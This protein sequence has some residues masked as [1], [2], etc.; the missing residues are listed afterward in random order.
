MKE[1]DVIKKLENVE[2]PVISVQS[3][4]RRLRM[5]LLDTGYLRK[6]RKVAV[7]ELAKNKI[8]GT[9]EI[10]LRGLIS[11]QPVWKMSAIAIFAVALALCL[12]LTLPLDSGSVY[13]QAEEIAQNSSELHSVLGAMN[14]E[15]IEITVIDIGDCEGTVLAQGG[16]G[17]VIA[18]VDLENAEVTEF[19]NFIID[20]EAAIEIAK[21]DPRVQELLDA[22]ATISGVSTMCYCGITGNVQTSEF[23]EFTEARV[24]VEIVDSENIY[25]AHVDMAGG[26]V[27]SI[28][29]TSLEAMSAGL[30]STGFTTVPDLENLDSSGN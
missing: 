24:M 28:T 29:E 15:E 19:F 2:L 5:A 14:G 6:Q 17:S 10:M 12:S 22:G 8:K 18:K 30:P 1:E 27:T 16:N 7:L 23:E 20:E 25:T 21:T 9:K 11:R 13:A 4:Q 3:H 26:K